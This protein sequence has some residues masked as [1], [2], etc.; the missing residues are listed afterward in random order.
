MAIDELA[1]LP[2]DFVKLDGS[3]VLPI[4]EDREA[5]ARVATVVAACVDLGRPVVAEYVETFDHAR[6]LV[7]VGCTLMQ[8]GSYGWPLDSDAF[9]AASESRV[10]PIRP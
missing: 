5:R 4:V 9:L 10:A 8:G 1:R 3:M 2:V 6:A 7:E